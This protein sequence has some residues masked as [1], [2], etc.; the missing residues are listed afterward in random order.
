VRLVVDADFVIAVGVMR[1]R[2]DASEVPLVVVAFDVVSRAFN[3]VREE[4]PSVND[5]RMRSN[6]R[7][8]A[9]SSYD[10]FR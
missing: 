4:P 5:S 2:F 8:F 1:R 3:G 7:F 9:S 6:L 10:M